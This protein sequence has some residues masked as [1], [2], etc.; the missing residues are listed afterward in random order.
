MKSTKPQPPSSRETSNFNFQRALSKVKVAGSRRFNGRAKLPLCPLIAADNRGDGSQ[1]NLYDL[2]IG[3]ELL[4]RPTSNDVR[5]L[6][7]LLKFGAS[8]ELGAWNLEF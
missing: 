2:K 6:N 8:L 4:L 1:N 7:W 3:A 5:S